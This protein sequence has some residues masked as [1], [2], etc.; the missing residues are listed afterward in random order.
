M[1]I[2]QPT[3]PRGR[4]T[5]HRH[6]HNSKSTFKVKQLSLPPQYASN[7]TNDTENYITKQVTN[8]QKNGATTNSESTT[9]KSSA[10]GA[11]IYLTS[12]FCCC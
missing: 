12:I 10:W 7:T 9:T 8:T 5:M 4:D 11:L 1:N 2:K 3:S 6:P